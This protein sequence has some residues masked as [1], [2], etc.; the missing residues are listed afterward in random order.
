MTSYSTQSTPI[1]TL[2]KG[3]AKPFFEHHPWVF[4]GAIAGEKGNPKPGDQVCVV[5]SDGQFVA[6]GLYNPQSQIRVRLYSWSQQIPITEELLVTRLTKAITFR[7]DHLMLYGPRQASRLVFSEGDGLS[8]LVV[9]S[10][11]EWLTVQWT[12][13]ALYEW[14]DCL[15][16]ALISL[17]SPRGI[18]LRTEKGIGE[19]EGLK[20]VDGPLWGDCPSMPI[21]I[22]EN[23]LEYEV[24]LRIGHKTGFYADQRDNRAF[25]APLGQGQDVLDLCC[26]T[27]GFGLNL[28]RAGAKSVLGIDSSEQ[29]LLLAQ[30]NSKRNGLI[31]IQFEK[32]DAFKMLQSLG[33]ADR[34]FGLVILDPPKFARS[35]GAHLNALDGYVNLNAAAMDLLPEDGILVTCSCSGLVSIEEFARVLSIAG[36]KAGRMIQ[37]LQKRGQPP[38]HPILASCP[39]GEYLK[40][41]VCRVL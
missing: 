35:K 18:Y 13:L 27:G 40:C 4:S 29:A 33:E 7:R 10:Y 32:G 15:V 5:S 31:N 39:E 22:V 37:I 2:K 9:D 34:K 25:V 41:F 36:N 20:I 38:D 17:C 19:A 6:W 8:G 1:V 3:R 23:D 24:D 11:D 14:K 30:N 26:Y 21:V 16:K 12:S 28:A